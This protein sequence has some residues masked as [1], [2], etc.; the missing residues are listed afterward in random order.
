[1]AVVPSK[2]VGLTKISLRWIQPLLTRTSGLISGIS[3]G[4]RHY[5]GDWDECTT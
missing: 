4:L 3:T 2:L 1:M 5:S